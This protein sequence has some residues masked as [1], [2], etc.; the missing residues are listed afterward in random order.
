MGDFMKGQD[1]LLLL[2]L[3]S[4][5]LSSKNAN[6]EAQYSVRA[7]AA[8]TGISK[9]EISLAL[10]RCYG[11]SLTVLD[12]KL[13]KPRVNKKALFEFI[14]YGLRYIF[15]TEI[16]RLSRGVT[17]SFAAPSL[18][19]KLMS[20]GETVYVWPDPQGD[21]KGQGLT[22]IYKTAPFAASQDAILYELLALVD[23]IRTG[24]ARER[25]LATKELA[26]YFEVDYE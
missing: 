16:G 17:T 7:L 5:E 6:D 26:K 10:Q 3:T 24:G 1:L 23:A 21:T 20:A 25:N 12:H 14:V 22:P 13:N 8:S 11:V 9:S 18:K 4:L 15:P 19:K 2:K